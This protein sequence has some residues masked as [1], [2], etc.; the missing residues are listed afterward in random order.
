MNK[1]K[2]SA[3]TLITSLALTACGGGGGGGSG[4]SDTKTE[5]T[6]L[7]GNYTYKA[8]TSPV[9][10]LYQPVDENGNP[11]NT[12][13]MKVS[14]SETYTPSALLSR[15]EIDRDAFA[16]GSILEHPMQ[17]YGKEVA[18]LTGYN[19][20][21]SM[22]G[23]IAVIDD[24]GTA[25]TI[26]DLGQAALGSNLSLLDMN[27]PF[28]STTW[29]LPNKPET[30]VFAFGDITRYYDNIG[31]MKGTATYKGNAT[32]YDT[33][34]AR[35]RHIGETT[36]NVNFDEKTVEGEIKTDDFRRNIVLEKGNIVGTGG[37]TQESITQQITDISTQIN[38]L[39]NEITQIR[40][41]ST[42]GLGNA[43]GESAEY[44][45]NL[46]TAEQ[47]ALITPKQQQIEDLKNYIEVLKNTANVFSGTAVAVGNHY[48]GTVY[49][50]TY[51]GHFFG[52]NAE[53]AAGIVV[54]DENED[55][56]AFSTVKQ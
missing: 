1:F 3:L 4:T 51:R 20:Q 46:T 13:K 27:E 10:G 29:R 23:A 26:L 33:V 7:N 52:P 39:N 31:L 45:P 54:F 42:G 21:Y 24:A 55:P 48:F 50:G 37:A 17:S 30:A 8:A 18:K 32:R 43:F 5:T 2:L 40:Q 15:L 16:Q 44:N 19:R 49:D 38:D 47:M 25:Q 53:E 9:P 41:G 14:A 34:S 12:R 6:Q 56:T 28:L 22:A 11:V 36:L 35:V